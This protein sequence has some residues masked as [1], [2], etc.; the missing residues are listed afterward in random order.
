MMSRIDNTELYTQARDLYI[1]TDLSIRDVAEQ[2]DLNVNNLYNRSM[3]ENWVLLKSS[4][5]KEAIEAKNR[6]IYSKKLENIQFYADVMD[7][8]KELKNL[9][10]NG[11][12]LKEV[13]QTNMLAEDRF[14]LLTS[15]VKEEDVDKT[16]GLLSELANY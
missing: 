10:M 1:S 5:I 6:I 16:T 3:K 15:V 7:K 11:K 2:F 4:K 14:Y 8:C 12:E 9:C 13:V